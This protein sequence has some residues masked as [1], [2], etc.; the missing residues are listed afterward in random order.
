MDITR[1]KIRDLRK[2][3]DSKEI[4]AV[5]LCGEY[6]KNI[7]VNAEFASYKI[8]IVSFVLHFYQAVNHLVPILTHSGTQR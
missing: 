1:A 2:A 3:L 8:N 4:G 6:F 5:E 7:A